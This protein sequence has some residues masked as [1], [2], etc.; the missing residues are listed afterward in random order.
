MD[1]TQQGGVNRGYANSKIQKVV[2]LGLHFIILL[3]CIYL[4]FSGVSIEANGLEGIVNLS[5][6]ARAGI[7]LMCANLY[8]L[9]HGITLFYLLVRRVDW[10]EVLGLSVFILLF[11]VGLLLIGGGVFRDSPVPLSGLDVVAI[12]LL[13][14]GSW[15]NTGSE[16]QRKHWKADSS[17]KGHCYTQGFFGYSMHINY[18]GDVVLFTGWCLFTASLLTLILPIFMLG[19]FMFVHIP[20]LDKYLADRYGIEF[21]TYR[22]K[23]KKLVPFVW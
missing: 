11:E 21:E 2:F 17:N 22:S 5:D 9:R 3:L 8:F 20:P 7:L 14:L 23:T 18:F 15:L 12:I 19:M 4:T 16:V 6:P 10:G 1:M 13:V